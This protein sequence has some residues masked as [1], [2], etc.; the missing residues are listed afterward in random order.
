MIVPIGLIAASLGACDVEQTDEGEMPD[1]ENL[2]FEYSLGRS[3]Q[4]SMLST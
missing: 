4:Q 3:H 1:V 2:S